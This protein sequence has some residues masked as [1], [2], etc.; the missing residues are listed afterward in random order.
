MEFELDNMEIIDSRKIDKLNQVSSTSER[1]VNS[2]SV[3]FEELHKEL[4]DY[5]QKLKLSHRRILL[6]EGENQALIEEKNKLFFQMKDLQEKISILNE[7]NMELE[8][9]NHYLNKDNL[10]LK[11]KTETL[12]K[13]NTTQ[14]SDLKRFT[15]F[16]LKIQNT[17]K[18][19]IENIKQRLSLVNEELVRS[20]KQ[21]QYLEVSK[22]NLEKQ[23]EQV[24]DSH[25]RQVASYE[26]NKSEL[27]RSYEEQIHSFSKEILTNQQKNEDLNLE[28]QRLKKSVEYKNFY[29]NEVIKF[30][31]IHEDD[32][33]RIQELQIELEKIKIIQ[34]DL[35]EKST[36]LIKENNR[37][38]NTVDE[39]DHVLESTRMQLSKQIEQVALVNERLNRLERLNIHLS[40]QMR[41]ISEEH[42]TES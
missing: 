34:S 14:L 13:I 4:E 21:S 25:K 28:I 19:Y 31:R 9:T 23:L 6:F 16:H 41:P 3:L 26:N 18:P 37:L 33:K 24:T 10:F 1:A 5:Q 8:R 40:Q 7:K 20:Q 36:Q 29:E 39:K 11:E 2:Q 22:E 38:N 15:K 32:Q 42:P 12:E 17:V 35:H 30:K 27:I